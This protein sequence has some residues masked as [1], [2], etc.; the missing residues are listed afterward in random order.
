MSQYGAIFKDPGAAYQEAADG[1]N[2]SLGRRVAGVETILGVPSLVIDRSPTGV[3][4]VDL[5]LPSGMRVQLIAKYA[6][7]ID[8]SAV[9][10]IAESIDY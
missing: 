2:T 4:A 9:K 7:Q 5:V 10:E 8:I 3:P 1:L 6:P